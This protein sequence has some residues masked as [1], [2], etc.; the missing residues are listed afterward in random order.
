MG[1]PIKE[2]FMER[3]LLP[4]EHHEQHMDDLKQ[5]RGIGPAIEHRLHQ[6]GILTFAQLA[7]VCAE[8][9][10][11]LFS[12]MHGLSEERIAEMGWSKQASLRIEK[13]TTMENLP[14]GNPIQYSAVFSVDLLLDN[15]NRVRRTHIVHVQ[16]SR[17]DSWAEWNKDRLAGFII[18]N[19]TV[20]SVKKG[21]PEVEKQPKPGEIVGDLNI[22]GVEIRAGS[23]EIT[24]W[25]VTENEPFAVGLI[26][27]MEK[28]AIPTGTPLQYHVEIHTKTLADGTRQNIGEDNGILE[29]KTFAPLVVNC[30]PLSQGSY[31]LEACVILSP[32]LENPNSRSR[33]MAMTEGKIFRVN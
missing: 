33:L 7:N 11:P 23:G 4:T 18:E 9:L 5:I 22:A 20:R 13:L 32:D 24:H 2:K 16:S 6:A 14:P 19:A 8:D 15:Q 26:L 30:H 25:R 17:E 28:T 27:D 12:D 10:A 31:R 3:A 1:D 29:S 21:P